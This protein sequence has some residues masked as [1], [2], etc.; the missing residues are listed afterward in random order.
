M[1]NGKESLVNSLKQRLGAL[2]TICIIADF[3]KRKLVADG[4]FMSKLVY[5]ITLWGRCENYL[6]RSLQTIQ[7]QAARAITKREWDMPRKEHLKQCGWLSVNQLSVYH[8]V[9]LVHNILLTGQ[10]LELFNMFETG[11]QYSSRQCHYSACWLQ[12]AKI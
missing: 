6:I 4:I 3:K 1:A 9:V 2:K 12:M 7:S 5:L 10:P 11:Y 8:T